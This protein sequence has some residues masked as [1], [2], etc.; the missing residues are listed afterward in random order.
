RSH[1][2]TLQVDG[3]TKTYQTVA[4]TVGDFLAEAKI[5]LDNDDYCQP[6]KSQVIDRALTVKVVRVEY[7]NEIRHKDLPYQIVEQE[8]YDLPKGQTEL[9]QPGF[10]GLEEQ[11][12]QQKYENGVLISE[13][14]TSSLVV[15]EPVDQIITVGKSEDSFV[16]IN[17][18]NYKY[19]SELDLRATA[20][21]YTGFR[22]ATG[23]N[24]YRGIVAVDT[25]VIP[26]GTKLYIEG[27]GIAIAADRGGAIKGNRVDLF[28][29][30]Y[31][32]A[33]HWGIKNVKAYVLK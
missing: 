32:E 8:S 12:W 14:M 9:A 29:E 17:G 19:T 22:T 15:N 1:Q 28:M 11:H 4:A 5:T 21:T 23:I 30:S 13:N 18:V 24:P 10:N 7:V 27:Y 16:T 20:Y 31:N 2:I 33:I 25:S 26:F 6:Q 3:T